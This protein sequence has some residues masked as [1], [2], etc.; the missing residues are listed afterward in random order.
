MRMS[1]SVVASLYAWMMLFAMTPAASGQTKEQIAEIKSL[2]T[3]GETLNKKGQL[4]EAAAA[5]DLALEKAEQ[6]CGKDHLETATILQHRA[7]LHRKMKEYAKAESLHLRG[8]RIREGQLGK[9]HVTV[10][11]SLN[12]L[13]IV[14]QDN[15]E[16]A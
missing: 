15:A 10:A 2:T 16:Y 1:A 8:L 13:A 9:D 11:G 14:Y 4:A 7:N 5:F 6:W 3:R 12:D